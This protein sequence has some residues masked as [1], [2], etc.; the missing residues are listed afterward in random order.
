MDESYHIDFLDPPA[1]EVI[2][3]GLRQYNTQQAGPEHSNPLCFVLYAP[4]QSIVG[5]IIG[6]THLG[7]LHI[8]LMWIQEELRGR[9]FGHQLIVAAEEEGHNR[10]STH[11]YLDT[12]IF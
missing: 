6:D 4:D 10:C 7:W 3:N 11:P 8:V 5:G 1:W 9:G 12:F 2:G